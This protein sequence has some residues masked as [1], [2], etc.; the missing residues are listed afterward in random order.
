LRLSQT[1]RQIGRS[2]CKAPREP[3]PYCCLLRR[4][5]TDG[6]SSPTREQE[7]ARRRSLASAWCIGLV[8]LSSVGAC[9]SKPEGSV[10]LYSASD[11][12]YA[13]PILD[14]FDRAHPS[15]QT[16]R[17]F[18]VEASKTLGLVTRIEQEQPNPKCDVFWNNEIVHTIRLQKKGLLAPHRWSIPDNWPRNY[19]ASDGT[20]VGVAARARVLLINKDKLPDSTKWPKSVLALADS[21]WRRRCGMSFPMYGTNATHIAVLYTHSKQVKRSDSAFDWNSWTRNVTENAVILAGNKQVAQAVSRG[22][23]DWGLTDTDDAVIEKEN[24]NNVEIMFPDQGEGDMGTILIPNTVAVLKNA[25]RPIAAA[26]LADYLVSEKVESRLTMSNS[27]HLPLWPNSKEKP[28]IL[29]DQ[30]IRWAEVNFEAVAD[31]WSN[32]MPIIQERF[33]K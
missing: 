19:R 25:P 20:W 16:V 18:D 21:G 32:V 15:T 17:Q 29:K 28:R 14:A 8:F 26:L 11:R 22:E 13:T 7:I 24:G 33:R 10:T 9:V 27:A 31:E 6:F 4:E 30:N 3:R 12:E 2:D 1:L 5:G 23:I